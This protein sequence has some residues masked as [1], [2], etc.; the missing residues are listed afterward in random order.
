MK[1]LKV[2]GLALILTSLLLVGCKQNESNN[3]LKDKTNVVEVQNNVSIDYSIEEQVYKDENKN[4][5]IKYPLIKGLKGELTMDY[6]N[7]SLSNAVSIYKNK[8]NDSV[9][10]QKDIKSELEDGYFDTNIDYKITRQDNEILS[11]VYSGEGKIRYQGLNEDFEANILSSKNI[12]IATATE[13]EF[14]NYIK[15]DKLD[16]V[17]SIL[18]QKAKKKGLNG[19]E[20]EGVRIYFKTDSVVFYYMPLDDSVK[21]FVEL[22]VSNEEL[23]GLVVE[24]F[25]MS[26]AS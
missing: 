5:V 10:S 9:N 4:I 21:E 19:F 6:I 16:E 22:E 1:L 12:D 3:D 2:M 13:I 23:K 15:E 7:Q 26:F 18:D 24:E 14:S 17:K 8:I 25:E 20:A 11:V